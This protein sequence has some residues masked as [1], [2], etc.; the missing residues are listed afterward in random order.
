MMGTTTDLR[1]REEFI[2]VMNAIPGTF[3]PALID[4]YVKLYLRDNI[5]DLFE[6]GEVFL[7]V[8]QTGNPGASTISTVTP[9]SQHRPLIEYTTDSTGNK[10]TLSE[11]DLISKGYFVKKD[12]AVKNLGN[13]VFDIKYPLDSRYYTSLS[14][15]VAVKRI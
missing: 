15:G 11:S 5:L 13:L 7:Y 6:I 10:I 3:D 14:M 1:A 4:D 12:A 9:T 8:L 2:K